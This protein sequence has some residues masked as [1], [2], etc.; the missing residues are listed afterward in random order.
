MPRRPEPHPE[1]AAIGGRV[2]K[3]REQQKLTLDDLCCRMDR[4]GPRGGKLT[5]GSLSNIEGGF[6]DVSVTFVG[7]IAKALGVTV[8]V[9]M[10]EV[11]HE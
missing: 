9:L 4:L 3:I 11:P 6:V 7:G 10:G 2:R 1:L 8:A 5:K